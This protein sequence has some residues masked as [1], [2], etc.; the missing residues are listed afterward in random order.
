MTRDLSSARDRLSGVVAWTLFTLLTFAVTTAFAADL[1]A[2]EVFDHVQTTYASMKAMSAEFEEET[3]M[4][5]QHR[6]AQGRLQFMKPG[7]LRQEYFEKDEPDL[8]QQVIVLDGKMSW[9]YTPWLNQVTRKAMDTERAQELLP[10][11]GANFENIP[12]NF[13]L[14]LKEDEVADGEA[15]FLLEMRPRPDADGTPATEIL[16]VW[17][18]ADGW[19]PLQFAY[20]HIPNRMTTVIRLDDVNFE[21]EL[22]PDVFTF[23]PP[24][25]VEVITITDRHESD[26]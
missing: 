6:V 25:G 17:I 4:D 14:A 22:E 15:I 9:A 26:G 10:G 23:T 24:V 8:L 7:L 12:E 21:A 18:L 16:E 20:S 3:I 2:L 1:T 11:A 13:D 19:Q 5:G